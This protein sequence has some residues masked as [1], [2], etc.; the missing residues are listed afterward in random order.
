MRT[1]A[2]LAALDALPRL[3]WLAEPT[4]VTPLGDLA[5]E[6]GLDALWVKRDDLLPALHGGTKVR[7]L[8][9][10]LATE[11]WAS[12][13]LLA[14]SG[15]IGSGHLVA[16]VSAAAEAGK[17]VEAHCFGEPIS[18]GVLDNLAC[19]ASGAETVCFHPTRPG[20]VLRHP[21]LLSAGRWRGRAV[22][23]PGATCPDGMLGV[24]RGGLEL[25]AQ[26]EAGELPCP[27]RVYVP[28]GSAGTTVGLALGLGLAGLSPTL[29]A[30]AVVERP[31]ATLGRLRRLTAALRRRLVALGVDI[32][33][34]APLPP[35]VV[36]RSQLGPGYGVPTPAALAACAR[37]EPAGLFL[38]PVYSGKAFA[39]LL[40]DA[41][42]R[43]AG[44]AL[45]WL[46]PRRGGP[47]PAAEGWRARLPASLRRWLS[48]VEP[49]PPP[50]APPA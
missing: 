41:A 24:V 32:A 20:V 5:A 36:D 11:P 48:K 10:L 2:L 42:A 25:A 43:P 40:A 37:L 46:T 33:A 22:I 7:K 49:S 29:H 23:P 34:D 8:D 44:R 21:W 17:R 45:L 30:V 18:A 50:A 3:G 16:V 1:S 27:D 26:V 19:T 39:A 13:E 28:L 14:S 38:E 35:L 6:L 47:L 31:L 12:A 4:P 15:A 9:L